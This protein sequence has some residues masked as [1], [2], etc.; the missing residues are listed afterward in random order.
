VTKTADSVDSSV[1]ANLSGDLV[2]HRLAHLSWL[3]PA[4]LSG[5]LDGHL[6]GNLVALLPGDGTAF[7][8]WDGAALLPGDSVALLLG[9]LGAPG[10]W[11][12]PGGVNALGLWH[13]GASWAGDKAGV[14]DWLLVAD[15][16]DLSLAP[17]G[18]SNDLW[19]GISLALSEMSK[20]PHSSI[21]KA[22]SIGSSSDSS[23]TNG[24][25]NNRLNGNLALNSNHSSL[26]AVLSFDVMALFNN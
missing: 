21:S 7:L 1:L 24:C 3:V 20:S 14:L 2:G 8:P 5:D 26:G 12:G 10:V 4:G 18:S 13:L 23:T 16:P 19:L 6:P 15:T 25:T 22:S 11:D 17:W 9:N